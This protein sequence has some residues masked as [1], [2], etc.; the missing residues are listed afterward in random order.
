MTDFASRMFFVL[1]SMNRE[2]G[3]DPNQR[4]S[5]PLVLKQKPIPA[6]AP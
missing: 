2:A 4:I 6:A 3:A 1:S 5:Q